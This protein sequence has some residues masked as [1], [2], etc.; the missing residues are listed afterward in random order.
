MDKEIVEYVAVEMLKLQLNYANLKEY[1]DRQTIP[2]T[3]QV[4]EFHNNRLIELS[5]ILMENR[6]GNRRSN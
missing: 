5:N 4:V 3:H 2:V 1:D 6:D